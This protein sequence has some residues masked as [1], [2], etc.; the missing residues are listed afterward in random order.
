MTWEAEIRLPRNSAGDMF[1]SGDGVCACSVKY[2][3]GFPF[4]MLPF[5]KLLGISIS[6]FQLPNRAVLHKMP[7]FW[8]EG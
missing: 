4:S 3:L 2:Q 1:L 8:T 6:G 7:F 5:Q